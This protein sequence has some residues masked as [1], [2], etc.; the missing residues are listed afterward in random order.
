[1]RRQTWPVQVYPEDGNAGN[2]DLLVA[3]GD[4]SPVSFNSGRIP[5]GKLCFNLGQHASDP[6]DITG[7]EFLPAGDMF[8]AGGPLTTIPIVRSQPGM[9]LSLK[10]C[11]M[12]QVT[13]HTTNTKY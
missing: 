11:M 9:D 7:Y 8:V 3:L 13:H 4:T 2:L 6:H 5:A 12:C 10:R 1:M